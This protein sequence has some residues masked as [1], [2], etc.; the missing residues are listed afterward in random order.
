MRV[1]GGYCSMIKLALLITFSLLTGIVNAASPIYKYKGTR[2]TA[3]FSTIQEV[4]QAD[5]SLMNSVGNDWKNKYTC[6]GQVPGYIAYYY[7]V[8]SSTGTD[9]NPLPGTEV[10]VSRTASCASGAVPDTTK[11]SAQQ[12]PD[13]PPPE[14]CLPETTTG[15]VTWKM[16]KG[17]T[18]IYN[19]WAER[20]GA[21][22]GMGCKVEVIEVEDCY[23]LPKS[24]EPDIGYCTFKT[25]QSG[26]IAENGLPGPVVDAYDHKDLQ[27]ETLPPTEGKQDGS[28]PRGTV[29]AGLSSS[30]IPMC[31]GNGTKPT[32]APAAPPK[33]EV[34][35]NET[36]PDGS[37]Q[38]TK[39]ESV[40]NKDGSVTKTTTVTI[41]K[42]TGEKTIT[43][44]K[45]T[46]KNSSGGSGAETKPEDK[47]DMCKNNPLLSVC[48]N[49]SVT[50]KCAETACS[51]D[52]IQCATLRAAAILQ[53]KAEKDEEAL[54]AS[55][56]AAKGQS[57]IDGKDLEGLP[58]PKN[59]TFVSVPG[60]KAEG[61]LGNGAAFEDVSFSLQGH[62]VVMPLS[63]WSSYLL[64][65][66]YVMMI[67]ASLISY[68]ILA[69]A[70]LKE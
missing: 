5:V 12:C 38:N 46:G 21:K 23:T 25:R 62:E 67:I 50:G 30:G 59:G 57:A 32:N 14:T 48:K 68:R 20:P 35:K 53:C 49:S 2:S 16:W 6:L 24:A 61:W 31:I 39:T 17:T 26:G 43:Q 28:C 10:V 52:A 9:C 19:P 37:K 42:P 51:G 27:D 7:R 13:V 56:L 11:P 70:V 60:M 15:S 29:N 64:P 63:K 44:E 66:R 8:C 33:V 36:L 54:K 65:L 18:N 4:C 40:T 22:N 34:E 55:P 47:S 69:G 58:G 45:D 41:T 1:F 3:T